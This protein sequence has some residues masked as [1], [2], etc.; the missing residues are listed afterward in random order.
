[1][2]AETACKNF[3]AVSC[4]LFLYFKA[5]LDQNPQG[6]CVCNGL[7]PQGMEEAKKTHSCVNVP[8][9]LARMYFELCL[10]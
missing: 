3:A 8:H 10:E 9:C 4:I 5:A 6:V 1:M 2:R 7:I